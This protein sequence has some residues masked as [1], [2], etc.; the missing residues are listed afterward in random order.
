MLWDSV[1]TEYRLV[2]PG[3]SVGRGGAVGEG[4]R[5]RADDHVAGSDRVDLRPAFGDR[6]DVAVKVRRA[7]RVAGRPRGEA[8]ERDV[9]GRGRDA[10]PARRLRFEAP[11]QVGVRGAR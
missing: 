1:G 8:E 5:R 2:A 3:G 6:D 10:A 4:E 11:L 7:L 9:V